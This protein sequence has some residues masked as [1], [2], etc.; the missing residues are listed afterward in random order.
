MEHGRKMRA[1]PVAARMT[2][3][4]VCTLLFVAVG[5]GGS[6]VAAAAE[7][8][9]APAQ[10]RCAQLAADFDAALGQATG[11]CEKETDCGS[12]SAGVGKNC[13]GA[14]DKAS[15]ARL[16]TIK[17]EFRSLKCPHTVHCAPR[18]VYGIECREGRCAEINEM[19]P[20]KMR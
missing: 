4:L 9:P 15:A 2:G 5:W 17:E 18:K 13:G 7:P 1:A 12:Y 6:G 19:R 20:P 14:T 3:R 8:D 11:A 10:D 16:A